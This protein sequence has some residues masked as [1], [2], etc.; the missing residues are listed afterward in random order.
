MS[1]QVLPLDD[2][3]VW[4]KATS[5]NGEPFEIG[6]RKSEEVMRE[7]SQDHVQTSPGWFT[8]NV[9]WPVDGQTWKA[10][11]KVD[12][13]RLFI[14]RYRLYH[15]PNDVY[16]YRLEF[17]NIGGFQFAFVDQNGLRLELHTPT[18]KTYAF[19]YNS[20]RPTIV[21]VAVRF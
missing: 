4:T 11:N 7:E 16:K 19:R 2:D 3:M 12:Q 1:Y 8:Y 5:E 6:I 21:K 17:T 13:Q 18:L 15:T 14:S 20:S 10:V 9:Y